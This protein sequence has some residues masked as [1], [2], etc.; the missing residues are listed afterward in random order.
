MMHNLSDNVNT[1][2]P[3]LNEY[4]SN[5]DQL[6]DS[7]NNDHTPISMREVNSAIENN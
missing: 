1:L 3:S 4:S 2:E 5:D 6:L 7:W